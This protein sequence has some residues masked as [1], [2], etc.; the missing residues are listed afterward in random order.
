MQKQSL[1]RQ[2][3]DGNV[4]ASQIDTE[5]IK[6]CF[7]VYNRFVKRCF[8]FA[9]SLLLIIVLSPVLLITALAVK[10]EDGGPVLYKAERGGYNNRVFKIYKF[11]SMVVNADSIGGGTTAL[12][13]DRI[14]KVGRVIRKIKLD[15][16][17]NLFNVIKGDMSFIGPRPELLRY[18]S[19]YTGA[20]EYILKVRPGMTDYS[21][22]EFINLDEIVGS[23]NADEMYEKYVLPEKNKLRVKYAATVSLSTDIKLFFMTA[24]KVVE[25]AFGFFF[26]KEHR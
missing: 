17:P 24:W 4:S 1:S 12:H 19:R 9:L 11:R 23:G 6:G 25:K 15:E 16:F 22:I 3:E 26:K 13:D 14:T 18:T 2:L 7:G 10:A 8:D 20:E 5:Y 21:S